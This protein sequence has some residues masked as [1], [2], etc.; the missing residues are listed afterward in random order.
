LEGVSVL[1]DFFE[2][3]TARLVVVLTLA[4]PAADILFAT[5]DVAGTVPVLLLTGGFAA[6]EAAVEEPCP[7]DPRLEKELL[8]P[9]LSLLDTV[10]I[11][12]PLLAP[13]LLAGLLGTGLLEA[14]E[15]SFGFFIPS[16]IVTV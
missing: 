1:F 8:L 14:L 3:K 16:A 9:T 11:D 4:F 13:V 5:E 12:T 15:T 7:P 6:E 2:V 10:R